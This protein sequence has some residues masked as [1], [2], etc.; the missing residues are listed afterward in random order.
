MEFMLG[1]LTHNVHNPHMSPTPKIHGMHLPQI[2]GR[3]EMYKYMHK[4]K[5]NSH[6]GA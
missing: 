2:L 6:L 1:R 4:E 5:H 3:I